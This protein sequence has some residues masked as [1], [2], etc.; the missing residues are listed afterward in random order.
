M[1]RMLLRALSDHLRVVR[2]GDDLRRRYRRAL[3]DM[4]SPERWEALFR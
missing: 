2:E 1:R 3:E 4:T